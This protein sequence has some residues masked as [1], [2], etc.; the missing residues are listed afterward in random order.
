MRIR[1]NLFLVVLAIGLLPVTVQAGHEEDEQKLLQSW[2]F[3]PD[4]SGKLVFKN[5]PQTAQQYQPW[6]PDLSQLKPHQSAA[7]P[8][9]SLQPLVVSAK[10]K[11]Q[12]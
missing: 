5:S 12:N 4:D 11:L 2:G 9:P 7:P 10:K 6:M 8:V 1:H 3:Q